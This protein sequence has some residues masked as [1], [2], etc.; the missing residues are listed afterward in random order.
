MIAKGKDESPRPN[1]MNCKKPLV[2]YR[3]R[4]WFA[5][6]VEAQ[7][8]LRT[9]ERPRLHRLP[10]GCLPERYEVTYGA[11]GCNGDGKFCSIGC[12][13]DWAVREAR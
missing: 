9:V 6:L 13:Y 3:S 7:R 2:R 10:S 12:G 1:C 4:Q 8:F 11:W 5:E